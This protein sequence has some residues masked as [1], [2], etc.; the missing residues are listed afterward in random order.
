MTSTTYR[1][2]QVTAPGRLELVEYAEG[3]I[4]NERGLTAVPDELTV[5]G[6]IRGGTC[7]GIRK[8]S[9]TRGS[10]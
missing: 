2:V 9:F 3:M 8:Q 1:A 6:S 10:L 5:S 4:A 7:V